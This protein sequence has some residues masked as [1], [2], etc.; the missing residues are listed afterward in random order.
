MSAQISHLPVILMQ[1]GP[2]MPRFHGHMTRCIGTPIKIPPR[3]EPRR[4]KREAPH[5][6]P[7]ALELTCCDDNVLLLDTALA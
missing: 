4:V 3:I 2:S 6:N 1:L 5:G 7:L